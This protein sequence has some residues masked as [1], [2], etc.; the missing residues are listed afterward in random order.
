MPSHATPPRTTRRVA[1]APAPRWAIAAIL[2]HL[3]PAYG[4]AQS[5][6]AYDAVAELVYT[7]LS[8]HTS[9]F[10]SIPAY[11]RLRE[12]FADWDAITAAPAAQVAEAVKQ[13][14]LAQVK[15][16][17]IQQ[18]LREVKRRTGGYDLS[19]LA[20]MPLPEAKAWLRELPG[21]GPKTVGCVLL[22]ALDMPALPVDTHV[23]RVA[24]RLGLIGP[25]VT[26]D[27]S[28]DLLEAML[29][30][31]QVLPFHMYLIQHGRV[32]CKAQRPRCGDC[33]LAARCPSRQPRLV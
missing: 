17:R 11:A 3:A 30:P 24:Q 29:L 6:R 14:G 9:D 25:K 4:P 20:R 19:F 27:A 21:V 8:Q 15:A 33:V 22:F 12:A 32:V 23:Y 13:G 10:N 31:Q 5:P 2:D 28:H 1:A 26:A 18:V 16:P 7:I